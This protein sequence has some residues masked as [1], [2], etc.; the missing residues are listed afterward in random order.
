MSK[1]CEGC[2]IDVDIWPLRECRGEDINH[3]KGHLWLCEKKVDPQSLYHI[4]GSA[5]SPV[6]G[7]FCLIIPSNLHFM[8]SY[9]FRCFLTHLSLHR[10]PPQPG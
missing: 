3:W 8:C 9:C 6:Q 5:C 2:D 10:V 1:L 7:T 4:E